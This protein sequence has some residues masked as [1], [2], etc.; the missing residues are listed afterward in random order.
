M[1][2]KYSKFNLPVSDAAPTDQRWRPPAGTRVTGSRRAGLAGETAGSLA[3]M[4]VYLALWNDCKG[5]L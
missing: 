4:K 3:S 1:F 5:Y 2:K